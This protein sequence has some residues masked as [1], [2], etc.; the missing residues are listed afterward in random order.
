MY[1]IL[2]MNYRRQIW[3]DASIGSSSLS[4]RAL[5]GGGGGSFSSSS[6]GATT[7]S[8]ASS[9]G[10]L[11]PGSLLVEF[12]DSE[13]FPWRLGKVIFLGRI[14]IVSVLRKN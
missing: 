4:S 2:W 9:C 12:L 6:D 3:M 5:V 10:L 11:I 14:L 8:S 7:S 1:D 13:R